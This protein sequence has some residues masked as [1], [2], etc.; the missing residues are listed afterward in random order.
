MLLLLSMCRRRAFP[1]LP[2]AFGL[3]GK[4]LGL[5][6]L[7]FVLKQ[8][9]KYLLE[10]VDRFLLSTNHIEL[11]SL[12]LGLL[13]KASGHFFRSVCHVAM[14]SFSTEEFEACDSVMEECNSLT[15]IPQDGALSPL[16]LLR[17]F[18]CGYAGTLLSLGV[19][20]IRADYWL[21]FLSLS[22]RSS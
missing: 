11:L 6:L 14:A 4:R 20:L 21:R 7:L 8:L 1:F 16:G 10:A 5:R 18:E 19:R 2:F 15:S 3:L 17:Q 13:L 9:R 12:D 22:W